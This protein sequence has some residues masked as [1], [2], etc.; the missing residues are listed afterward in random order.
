[1]RIAIFSDTYPPEINGVATSARNLYR[2]FKAHGDSVLVVATNPYNNELAYQN[3]VLRL[4]GIDMKHLYD[5]RWASVYNADAMKLI[6]E[7]NPEVIHIQ[8]DGGVGQF[9]FIAANIL[10][11]ATV[12]TFHTMMED[13]T[14]YATRGYFDRAAKSIVRTYVRYKSRRAD[15]FITPSIKIQEYMR[16]IGVDAYMNVIPTGIDFSAFKRE[17]LDS[18]KVK[19]LKAKYGLGPDV[20]VI[21]SLG[22][23]AKEKSIDICLTGYADY[24][25]TGPKKPTKFVIVGGGPALK[26][27]KELSEEL[28]ISDHVVFVG[29]V[30]PDSVPLYY[31]LG[32]LFVSASITETQGLTFM[33]AMASS[34]V[35]FARYDESLIGTIKDGEDGFFFLDS[36]DFAK[37]LPAILA[38][39]NSRLV[40]V[41]SAALKAIEPY[42]LEKFYTRVHE[43]YE[44]AIKKNW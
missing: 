42:S 6:K 34:L 11:A 5:Y 1:M 14:Y 10:H 39:P 27:L 44:R 43:V 2:T 16:N 37:K 19:E 20:Y 12:Y 23:V 13:Y 22:R 41:K 8:T 40:S 32:D 24:L 9:G 18:K 36:T 33:E 29:P 35:L 28:G 17:S 31:A 3:D 7:F 25:K 4:P 26:E 30:N 21:L 15:E 38:L